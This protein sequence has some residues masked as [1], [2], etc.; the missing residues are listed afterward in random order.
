MTGRETSSGNTYQARTESMTR[1]MMASMPSSS[2]L[3]WA[4]IS[5]SCWFFRASC[6]RSSWGSFIPILSSQQRLQRHAVGTALC[7]AV[8][9]VLARATQAIGLGATRHGVARA[10]AGFKHQRHRLFHAAQGLDPPLKKGAGA[11]LCTHCGFR[12]AKAPARWLRGFA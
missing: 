8:L 7:A 10:G 5:C 3:S 4:A 2:V 6:A 12:N 9:N 11:E 1:S